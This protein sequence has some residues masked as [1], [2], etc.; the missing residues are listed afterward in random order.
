MAT[1]T[2]SRED[3]FPVGTS[4]AAYPLANWP[5]A[6]RPPTGAPVGSS[7]A[8]GTVQ[9]NG[10]VTFTGLA[11]ATNYV[12]YAQVSGVHRYIRFRTP[13]ASTAAGGS[14]SV[15]TGAPGT[16]AD[17]STYFELN[18]SGQTVGMWLGVSGVPTRVMNVD[19]P[20]PGAID[21]AA[22]GEIYSRADA[23][24]AITTSTRQ[25]LS[26]GPITLAG[27][28]PITNLKIH[29]GST[30]AVSPVHH[31][32]AFY[33]FRTGALLAGGTDLLTAAVP[34][35]LPADYPISYTPTT[36]RVVRP[37]YYIEATTV[38]NLQG[39]GSV[40]PASVDPR[41]GGLHDTL[42]AGSVPA[43]LPA[44][45]GAVGAGKGPFWCEW[46]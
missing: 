20:A 10:V 8:S 32:V 36:T 16:L 14:A 3:V 30:A 22:L 2:L 17:G 44:T 43:N 12:A 23:A 6:Q 19:L 33:D 28:V 39:K 46:K 42:A 21:P 38:P 13:A 45:I 35:N 34:V 41:L 31:F 5:T 7:A 26:S 27:G 15:G 37:V 29:T 4:V 40:Q 24:A 18:S 9:A 11:D 25:L 1:Q